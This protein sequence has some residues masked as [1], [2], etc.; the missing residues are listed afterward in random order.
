MIDIGAELQRAFDEW[1]EKGKA[2][3]V[4]RARWR[5]A[6]FGDYECSLC[7]FSVYGD[8]YH[9][10]PNCGAKMYEEKDNAVD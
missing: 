10:C 4:R 3:Q 5:G 1:Y 6:G 7:G 2:E 8:Q 9:Y